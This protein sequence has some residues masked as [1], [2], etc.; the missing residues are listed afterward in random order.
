MFGFL[1]Q[2][3][4]EQGTRI[5]GAMSK[6]HVPKNS[7]FRTR[8]PHPATR[9]PAP[10]TRTFKTFR[11]LPFAFPPFFLILRILSNKTILPWSTR[12]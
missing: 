6:D 8:H 5:E 4:L 12:N 10:E 7:L 2:G 1:K 3:F 11:L 9:I